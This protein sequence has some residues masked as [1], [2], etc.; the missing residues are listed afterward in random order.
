MQ[1]Y[2]D[3][4]H[5]TQRESNLTMTMLQDIPAFDEQDSSKLE[6]CFMDIEAA[7]TSQQSCTWLAEAKSHG[8]SHTFIYKA[9]QTEKCWVKSRAFSDWKA[10][11]WIS[12]LI[13]HTLWRYNWR[14]MT[15]LLPICIASKQQLSKVLLTMALW[16]STFLLRDFEMH[17]NHC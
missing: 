17:P 1:A 9:T 8:L 10:V 6:E 16:K 4:L 2:T 13:L 15:F 5:T 11:M 14:T 3:T 7:L 12:I